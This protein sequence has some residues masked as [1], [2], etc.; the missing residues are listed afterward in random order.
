MKKMATRV[1]P[2]NREGG[3]ISTMAELFRL[4]QKGEQG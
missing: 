1:I 4:Y 2:S 3:V